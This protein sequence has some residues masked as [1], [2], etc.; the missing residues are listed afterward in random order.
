MPGSR[1]SYDTQ[2][3]EKPQSFSH[4]QQLPCD[5]KTTRHNCTVAPQIALRGNVSSV[6]IYIC[7]I[8]QLTLTVRKTGL[9]WFFEQWMMLKRRVSSSYLFSF[10]HLWFTQHLVF[11]ILLNKKE[12]LIQRFVSRRL[13][14]AQPKQTQQTLGIRCNDTHKA[15]TT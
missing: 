14:L 4:L 12:G 9:L 10:S 2:L 7:L 3:G 6:K 11:I 13:S 15:S 5:K 8:K 1:L